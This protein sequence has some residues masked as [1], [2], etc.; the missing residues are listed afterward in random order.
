MRYMNARE[1][2]Q[3]IDVKTLEVIHYPDPRLKE[4]CTP[5]EV[6]DDSVRALA[7]KMAELMFTANGVGLAAPQV[8]VTVRMFIASPSFSPEDLYAYINPRIVE[9]S[10]TLSEEEG[11]LSFPNIFCKIK[12]AGRVTVEAI[13]LD[14]QPFTRTVEGLHARIIQHEN[15]HLDGI[16]L[17]DRMGSV[18]KL[19]K[20]HALQSL[21]KQYA[22]QQA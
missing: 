20:R 4:V 14:G 1:K 18:A 9:T 3:A 5:L 10:G 17:S 22:D 21:E 7:H 11:C 16:L 2:I 15:D 12:R 13:G 8:G 19:A 6:V